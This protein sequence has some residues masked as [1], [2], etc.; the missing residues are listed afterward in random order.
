MKKTRIIIAI[1]SFIGLTAFGQDNTVVGKITE[2]SPY[3]DQYRITVGDASLVLLVDPKDETHSTFEINKKYKNIL[4]KKDGK[5]VLNPKYADKTFKIEF[6]INGKG[7]KCIKT[8]E[9]SKK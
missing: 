7:W 8:I 1:L 9:P 4:V 6:E 2:V 3:N 5:F